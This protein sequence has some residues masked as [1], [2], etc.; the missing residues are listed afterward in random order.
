MANEEEKRYYVIDHANKLRE[1]ERRYPGRR[2]SVTGLAGERLVA[3][4][5]PEEQRQQAAGDQV[6][7]TPDRRNG[8]GATETLELAQED[9]ERK[10]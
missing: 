10:S 2:P 3:D 7:D 1:R 9:Y 6:P 8:C 4:D 5:L